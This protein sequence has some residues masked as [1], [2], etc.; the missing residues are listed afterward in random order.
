VAVSTVKT[1]I[2]H[3]YSKLGVRT[4]ED[5]VDRARELGLL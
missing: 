5:A 4:R 2:N 1:H 3:L